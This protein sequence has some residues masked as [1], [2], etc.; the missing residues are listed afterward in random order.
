[1]NCTNKSIPSTKVAEA[2]IEYAEKNDCD[3]IVQMNQKDLTIGEMFSGTVGQKI[4]EISPIP[5]MTINPMKRESMSHFGS[6][7]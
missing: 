5:V 2:I 4:V 1:M 7:M 3:L 6:G